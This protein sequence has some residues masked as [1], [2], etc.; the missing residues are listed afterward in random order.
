MKSNRLFII[1]SVVLMLSMA[2]TACAPAAAPTT[3]PVAPAATTAPAAPAAPAATTAPAAPAATTAPAA[4]AATTAPAAPAAAGKS[5]KIGFL[6]G[7]QDPFYY[8]MERG[9]QQ[10]AADLGVTLVAQYPAKWDAT[11]QTPMLDAMVA[12][13]DLN[14][15]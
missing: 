11:V 5:Y 13:G 15:L 6:A 3:A 2:L 7:V 1:V 8:T 12:R 14:F 9:M 10:A 4:P